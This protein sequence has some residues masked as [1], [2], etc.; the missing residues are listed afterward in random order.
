MSSAWGYPTNKGFL[1]HLPGLLYLQIITWIIFV[2]IVIEIIGQ[3]ILMEKC[4]L[5]E[6]KHNILKERYDNFLEIYSKNNHE[7][8]RLA[9]AVEKMNATMIK[10][11]QSTEDYKIE[12]EKDEKE[13]KE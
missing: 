12:R 3:I 4:N 11:I 9:D 8:K 13:F 10:H 6:E 2:K 5:I 7:F 1:Y